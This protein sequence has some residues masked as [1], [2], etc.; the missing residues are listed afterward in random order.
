M[1]QKIL[2]AV[3]QSE[4]SQYVFEQGVFLA[5]ASDAELM[6]LH[7][8]SPL[9]DPYLSPVFTQPD[10]I[11]PS[12]QTAPIESYMREWEEL[13][14]QRLD[15][16]RSL[17]DTATNAGVK[18]GFTQNLGDAGRIICEVARNL[19]A[20]LIIVGRR[21]RTGISEFLLGSVSNYALH[22]A[23]CSMLIVQGRIPSN[24]KMPETV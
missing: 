4:T 6:L 3:D 19:P 21:G 13:K 18:A 15:W 17:S 14:K 20:D 11:Y 9:E 22:H 10:T 12:V 5:K 24:T 16:L 23:P 2:V 1:Y 7:V 8:L